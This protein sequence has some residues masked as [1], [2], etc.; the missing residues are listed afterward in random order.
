MKEIVKARRIEFQGEHRNDS[1]LIGNHGNVEFI[2]NGSFNL[3]GMIYSKKTVEFTVIGSGLIRFTG[4]CRRVIIHLVKGDS[5]LDLSELSSK[6]VCCFSLRDRSRIMIG[7]TKVIS[8]AN[9]QDEAIF[10]YAG[11]ALLRSYSVVGKA[12][13]EPAQS[14]NGA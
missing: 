1:L 9:V 3:S 11:S 6:E 12:R 7:P 4:F 5:V 10:N 2:A 14:Q 13:I 8:R